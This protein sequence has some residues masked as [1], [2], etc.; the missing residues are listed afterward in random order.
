MGIAHAWILSRP[1]YRP[2]VQAALDSR[3]AA[4][5]T[6]AAAS[7]HGLAS[8]VSWPVRAVGRVVGRVVRR[9]ALL[10]QLGGLSDRMLKDI[11]VSRSEIDGLA[12]HYAVHPG[13][14]LELADLQRSRAAAPKMAAA[15]PA[16]ELRPAVRPAP[17]SV[18]R[19]VVP[20]VRHAALPMG[21]AAP[22]AGCG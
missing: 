5:S 21:R 8:L 3:A 19:P 12:Q 13:V 4:L 2:H 9:R 18:V 16:R 17:A 20:A 10:R 6:T 15:V 1:E 7:W 11:G 22:V 14:R